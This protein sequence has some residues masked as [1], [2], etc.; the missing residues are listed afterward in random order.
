M[1]NDV[2][3]VANER[4]LFVHES[5]FADHGAAYA[6]IRAAAPWCEI[7]E[8]P[9]TLAQKVYKG[10]GAPLRA[11]MLEFDISKIKTQLGYRDS[12]APAQALADAVDWLVANPLA[13]G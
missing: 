1:D 12:I 10:G 8:V 11:W 9:P 6:A 13:P 3:A 7:V 4:T 5:A 2:V